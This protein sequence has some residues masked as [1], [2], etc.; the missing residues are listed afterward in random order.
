MQIKQPKLI[1]KEKVKK[2][3]SVKRVSKASKP[4]IKSHAKN[5]KSPEDVSNFESL[6]NQI[7]IPMYNSFFYNPPSE[8]SFQ[9][10]SFNQSITSVNNYNKTVFKSFFPQNNA[11]L[12]NIKNSSLLQ[13]M[14]KDRSD[15]RKLRDSKSFDWFI[16]KSPYY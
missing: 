5:L 10:G 8:N 13:K 11:K 7:K 1:K 14:T 4:I 6:K 9:I 16:S 3:D 2:S 12:S 15:S